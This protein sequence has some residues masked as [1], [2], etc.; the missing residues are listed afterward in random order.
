VGHHLVTAAAGWTET[1]GSPAHAGEPLVSVRNISKTFPGQIAVDDVSLDVHA[2]EVHAVVGQNGSGKSTLMKVLSGF[3]EADP[4]GTVMV[5]GE[6][7]DPMSSELARARMHFIHQELALVDSL[8]TVDNLGLGLGYQLGRNKRIRWGAS[9]AG[10]RRLLADL[11]MEFDV[12]EPVGNLSAVER[13]MVAVARATSHWEDGPSLLVLDE[14]AAAL[15]LPEVETLFKAIRR[16]K[17]RGAAI[18]YISHR[19]PE[20]FEIADR[21]T[22]LRGGR[23]ITTSEVKSL[24]HDELVSLI[25]GQ[26]LESL[27]STSPPARPTVLMSAR[28]LH[29]DGIH[30]VSFDLHGGEMLGITGLTGSGMDDLP[31]VLVGASP[32]HE[33]GVSIEG[34]RITPLNLRSTKANGIVLVPSNRAIKGCIPT[35]SVKWNLTLPH[36]GPVHGR[37]GL[38]PAREWQ[39]ASRWIERIDVRPADPERP[40]AT[41]SG[42]NQQKVIVAKWLRTNPRVLILHEPTHGVDIGARAAIWALL[43]ELLSAGGGAVICSTEIAD[44][45]H[46]CDRVLV[47]DGGRIVEELHGESLTEERITAA[48]LA[49]HDP[50]ST[51]GIANE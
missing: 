41:L 32:L 19:L 8:D 1:E 6:Q 24:D 29:A 34:R 42:G 9:I 4:G 7:V 37:F 23:L 10:A 25:V 13:T 44:L 45:A 33:G 39:D 18:L 20:V 2:G 36:L 26:R 49:A 30:E 14:V 3:H 5:M 47:M 50:A 35:H 43:A 17:A 48:V 21:V 38:S 16:L 31:E 51:A 15:P 11:G 28:D 27:Y 46:V 12:R 40:M 22:V